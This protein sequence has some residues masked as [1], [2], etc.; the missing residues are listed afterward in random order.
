MDYQFDSIQ[1]AVGYIFDN[2]PITIINL[3]NSSY[4]WFIADEIRNALEYGLNNS[5]M[6]RSLRFKDETVATL[7]IQAF[8]AIGAQSTN[9]VLCSYLHGLALNRNSVM[10]IAEPGLYDLISRSNAPRAREFQHWLYFDIL[11]TLRANPELVQQI[12][13]LTK[14]N[15]YLTFM[16]DSLSINSKMYYDEMVRLRKELKTY[17]DM[18]RVEDAIF[19]PDYEF[20][21]KY[22]EDTGEIEEY[23]VDKPKLNNKYRSAFTI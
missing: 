6:I 19:F 13:D 7:S 18:D 10:I 15:N 4:P 17:H 2:K 16:K 22:N 11:P 20:C 1:Q 9:E 8:R 23:C 3:P 12:N 21:A 14:Q 5:H